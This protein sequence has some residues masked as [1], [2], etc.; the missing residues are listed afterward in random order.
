MDPAPL[1]GPLMG[2]IACFTGLTNKSFAWA[3]HDMSVFA[4]PYSFDGQFYLCL[5]SSLLFPAQ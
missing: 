3:T 5:K 2:G 1:S 4:N